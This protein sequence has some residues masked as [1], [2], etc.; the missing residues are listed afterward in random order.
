MTDLAIYDMDKTVTRRP[1]YTPFLIHCAMRRNPLRLVFLPLVILSMLSYVLKLIDRGTLKEINHRLLLGHRRSQAELKPLVESFAE[2][3]IANNIRPGAKAAIA[4]D[5]AEGRMVVMATASYRFY[6][7][8]I[9]KRMG[10]D[11]VIGTNTI[12]GIDEEVHAKI[13]GKNCYGPAKMEMILDWETK[14][15]IVRGHVRFYSDHVTD[16][17]VFEWSDEPIAV[18][19]HGKLEELAKEQGWRIEDW[20]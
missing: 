20:G 17:P 8:E 7:Q 6:A 11:H 9:G 1:T 5:K 12:L 16:R 4:R 18:N 14:A 2:K 10:F 19:P 15:E 3:T 13:D